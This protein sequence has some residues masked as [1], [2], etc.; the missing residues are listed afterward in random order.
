MVGD[1]R[2]TNL[3]AAGEVAGTHL[4]LPGQLPEDGQAGRL[5]ERLKHP[6]VGIV[7]SHI[8][9]ISMNVIP[10]YRRRSILG[11]DRGGKA[12]GNALEERTQ[13]SSHVGLKPI[14]DQAALPLGANQAR[15]P[16][17]L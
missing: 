12:L 8:C 9:S 7:G 17:H 16:E 1:G 15:L 4:P 10:L 3:T 5:G 2:L 13:L 6:N 11:R 14:P